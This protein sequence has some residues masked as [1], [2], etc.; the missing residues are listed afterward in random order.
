MCEYGLDVYVTVNVSV[1]SVY[2]RLRSF[3]LSLFCFRVRN[4]TKRCCYHMYCLEDWFFWIYHKLCDYLHTFVV[5][6]SKTIIMPSLIA[7]ILFLSI[8]MYIL[9][10]TLIHDVSGDVLKSIIHCS[11]DILSFYWKF[12]QYSTFECCSDGAAS[13]VALY[14]IHLPYQQ[15]KVHIVSFPILW[16]RCWLTLF[17]TLL[18]TLW[19]VVWTSLSTNSTHRSEPLHSYQSLMTCH[20]CES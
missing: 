11:W 12:D 2:R 14:E 3:L 1:L 4:S 5:V 15:C 6:N 9:L 13:G 8:F 10:I 20:E 18:Y 17:L 19:Y 16:A 7:S